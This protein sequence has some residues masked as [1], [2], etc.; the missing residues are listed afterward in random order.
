MSGEKPAPLL[1][2]ALP[3]DPAK[4]RMTDTSIKDL[5]TSLLDDLTNGKLMGLNTFESEMIQIYANEAEYALFRL[6][7][8]NC[9]SGNK[10]GEL[11]VWQLKESENSSTVP[12]T[13]QRA[14]GRKMWLMNSKPINRKLMV[15]L[16][17]R[18]PRL[19]Q[20]AG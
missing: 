16:K 17:T 11:L 7:Q 19:P 4:M 2:P 14:A 18:H 1:S 12:K 10:V 3:P 13:R 8:T 6:K 15:R 5:E 20:I 9:E